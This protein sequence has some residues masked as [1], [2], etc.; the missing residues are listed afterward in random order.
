MDGK[1]ARARR[2]KRD[3]SIITLAQRLV[4]KSERKAS[5]YTSRGQEKALG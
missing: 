5:L 2:W 1:M 4:S 3:F